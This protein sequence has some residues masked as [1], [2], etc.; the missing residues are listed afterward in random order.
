VSQTDRQ[1]DRLM[2]CRI[3]CSSIFNFTQTIHFNLQCPLLPYGHSYKVKHPSPDRVK[4]S[5]VIFDIR[6]LLTLRAE[7]HSAR[8][9]TITNDDLTRSARHTM[10]YSCTHMAT[11]GVKGLTSKSRNLLAAVL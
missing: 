5:F 3:L 10:L 11:V 1:T 8:M 7:R 2:S 4:A 9:S 6:A